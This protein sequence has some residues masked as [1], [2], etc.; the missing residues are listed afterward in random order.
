[1]YDF[2][3]YAWRPKQQSTY[4]F[5]G[6]PELLI[7]DCGSG[8]IAKA[9]TNALTAFGVKTRA[10]LPGKPRGKGQVEQGNRLVETQFESRLRFEPVSSIEELNAAV[11]RWYAAYNANLI[12]GLDTRLRRDG[13]IVGVR[14]ALWQRIPAEKL[15]ELPD[16][17]I[18]RQVFSRGVQHR[19]V[20]GDLSIRH[21]TSPGKP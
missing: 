2:L 15:R 19:K 1:M 8:N 12:P 4:V 9:T 5:H 11:E 21:G 13:K 14:T 16:E 6:V 3:L 17:Q 10:H 20:A 18:C 7:W